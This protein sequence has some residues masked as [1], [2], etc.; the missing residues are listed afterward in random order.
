MIR[1]DTIHRHAR[2]IADGELAKCRPLRAVQA[3]QTPLVA[4][5]IRELAAAVADCLLERAHVDPRLD[6]A[7]EA[8]YSTGG[9]RGPSTQAGASAA[10]TAAFS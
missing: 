5:T 2:L 8:I 3:E 9:A 4:N 10:Q 6:A 1:R 7:L